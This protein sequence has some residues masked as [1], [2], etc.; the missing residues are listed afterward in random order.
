MG[1][2]GQAQAIGELA[3][4]HLDVW[5]AVA[6]HPRTPRRVRLLVAAALGY[7]VLPFD[8][9]PD[10]IPVLGQ[11]DDLMLA[12]GLLLLARRMIPSDVLDECRIRAAEPY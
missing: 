11:L 10:T 6:E 2:I 12:P 1:L 5:R 3:R 4:Y 9:I 7:L 8:L